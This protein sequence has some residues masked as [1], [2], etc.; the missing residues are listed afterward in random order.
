M[1]TIP[2]CLMKIEIRKAY[3][4]ISW[5]FIEEALRGFGFP[6][7]FVQLIVTCITSTKFTIK[8]NGEGIA[9]LQVKE[10]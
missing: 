1:K 7:Y 9:T 8:V 10:D 6:Q 4:M 2:R 5:E 3:D